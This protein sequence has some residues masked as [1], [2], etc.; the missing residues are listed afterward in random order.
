MPG[1]RPCRPL[2]SADHPHALG[3]GRGEVELGPSF[4][5]SPPRLRP[6]SDPGTWVKGK[7]GSTMVKG[8]NEVSYTPI[9]IRKCT[10]EDGRLI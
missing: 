3:V 10:I 6:G 5:S 7:R 8:Q 1:N 4:I 2:A 9:F